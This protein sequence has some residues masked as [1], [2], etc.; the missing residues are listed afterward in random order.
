MTTWT[1]QFRTDGGWTHFAPADIAH[2]YDK[3]NRGL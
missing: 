2:H 1:V 3:V